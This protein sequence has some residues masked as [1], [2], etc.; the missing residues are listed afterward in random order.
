M[1]NATPTS[2][3]IANR[4]IVTHIVVIWF[5]KTIGLHVMQEEQT[6][7]GDS[8]AE[9]K[10]ESQPTEEE[11]SDEEGDESTPTKRPSEA[12]AL[13]S[14]AAA[15]HAAPVTFYGSHRVFLGPR[16]AGGTFSPP[17]GVNECK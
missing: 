10:A 3:C 6:A 11:E 12:A 13:V 5:L 2:N 16:I 8:S 14:A 4:H 9:G 7:G 15:A 17:L 1:S